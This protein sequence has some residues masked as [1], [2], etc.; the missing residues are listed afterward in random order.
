MVA[1]RTRI[2][3]GLLAC[4]DERM[5]IV[6]SHAHSA[7]AGSN[8]VAVGSSES[9][10]WRAVHFSFSVSTRFILVDAALHKTEVGHREGR[11]KRSDD[12]RCW[13]ERALR[14][15]ALPSNRNRSYG[16]TTALLVSWRRPSCLVFLVLRRA[17]LMPPVAAATTAATTASSSSAGNRLLANRLQRPIT[18]IMR[19]TVGWF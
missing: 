13:A 5:R 18:F 7:T 3:P 19:I 17:T 16:T 9:T 6:K 8:F 4:L 1:L 12:G 11:R 15:T 10:H 2:R 14:N